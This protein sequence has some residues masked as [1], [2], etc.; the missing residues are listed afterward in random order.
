MSRAD[1]AF[2]EQLCSNG[3][4][5]HNTS[6][7]MPSAR[8]A[9]LATASATQQVHHCNMTAKCM[10]C[11]QLELLSRVSRAGCAFTEQLCST[12]P[13]EHNVS[14]NMPSARPARLAATPATQQHLCS[15]QQSPRA[16]MCYSRGLTCLT[17]RTSGGVAET[18][19]PWTHMNRISSAR[20]Q[21]GLGLH[22]SSTSCHHSR[23]LMT[24]GM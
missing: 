18:E 2:T 20:T 8:P 1:C 19:H 7:N 11:K 13:N 17:D 10:L 4:I 15:A 23:Q 16:C 6:V 5:A 3:P 22:A 9:R 21:S 12:G 14:V 24:S